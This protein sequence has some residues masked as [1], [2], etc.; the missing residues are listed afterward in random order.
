[1]NTT[2]IMMKWT[3]SNNQ[4][5]HTHTHLYDLSSEILDQRPVSNIDVIIPGPEHGHM[6]SVSRANQVPTIG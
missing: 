6:A 3:N 2:A 4:T 1:M 5:I